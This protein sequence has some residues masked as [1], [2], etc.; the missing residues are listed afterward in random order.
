MVHAKLI[1]I[2]IP[3]LEILQDVFL[4]VKLSSFLFSLHFNYYVFKIFFSSFKLK[5]A[6]HECSPTNNELCLQSAN[7]AKCELSKKINLNSNLFF[8]TLNTSFF[9]NE[10]IQTHLRFTRVLHVQATLTVT[11][12]QDI[13]LVNF[14]EFTKAVAMSAE[15]I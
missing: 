14:L 2:A 7:T 5:K 3:H 4:E 8:L 11:Q 1:W 13:P 12:A 6:C 15:T 10:Q 9:K